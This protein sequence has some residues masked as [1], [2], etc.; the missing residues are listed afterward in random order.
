MSLVFK[1]G[2]AVSRTAEPPI[3]ETS[4]DLA[5]MTVEFPR[6]SVLCE[7]G[8]EGTEMFILQSGVIDVVIGGHSIA[9]ISDPGTPIGEIALLIGEK[10]TATLRAKNTVTATRLRKADL[11][12]VSE[13]NPEVLSSITQSLAKKHHQNVM[14]L[15]ELSS[16][17]VERD[18]TLSDEEKS[19]SAKKAFAAKSE[20]LALKNAIGELVFKHNDPFLKEISAKYL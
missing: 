19:R 11:K 7:E 14:K 9:T 17:I 10:R 1:E 4:T 16:M 18:I 6:D 2:E 13:K 5:D 20:L 15:H 3:I 12:T 8:S